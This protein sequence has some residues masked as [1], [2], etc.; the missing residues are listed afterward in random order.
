M[1]VHDG[2]GPRRAVET[3]ELSPSVH[4]L[5]SIA[6]GRTYRTEPSKGALIHGDAE[7]GG[8]DL[9][10]TLTLTVTLIRP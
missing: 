1:P 2:K 9:T 5:V 10:L 4:D 7:L 6:L 3:A 8:G